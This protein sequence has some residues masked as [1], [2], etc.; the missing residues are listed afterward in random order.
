MHSAL[1][2]TEHRPWP[3]PKGNWLMQQTWSELLFAHWPFPPETIRQ[4]IPQE[5]ELDTFDQQA[6]IGVVPFQMSHIRHRLLPPIPGTTTFPEL[7]VRTYV[8]TQ[9]KPGVWFFSLDATNSLAIWAARR[10]F[11]LPYFKAFMR[12]QKD[13][14]NWIQ[15]LSRREDKRSKTAAF[16]GR[17][18]PASKIFFAEKDSI[19]HWLTERYCL[20][21][22]DNQ[23]KIYRGEIQHWPWPLQRAQAVFEN[24]DMLSFLGLKLPPQKPL[25]HYADYID[26]VVWKPEA[27]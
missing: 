1:Q 15:Y 14:Q 7:N 10:F 16:K 4:L 22:Q 18:Q 19:E 5:L 17:Y 21:S 8:K 3:L 9:G 20:Y 23:G 24:F 26:V 12:I 13:S 25:L 11:Y 27:V 2:K 6:W